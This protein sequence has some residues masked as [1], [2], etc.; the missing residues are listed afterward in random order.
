VLKAVLGLHGNG[1][2]T[3]VDVPKL[4]K[5]A[6]EQ[7]GLD[8]AG[9]RGEEPGA[10]QRRKLFG[11]LTT[12]VNAAAELRNAGSAPAWAAASGPPLT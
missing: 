8:P 9:H 11:A 7:L 3:K 12:I 2:E 1:P 10:E 5:M 4:V 6:G